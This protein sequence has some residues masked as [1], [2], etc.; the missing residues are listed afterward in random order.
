MDAGGWQILL[1]IIPAFFVGWFLLDWVRRPFNDNPR[2][3]KDVFDASPVTVIAA[4]TI[5]GS[6]IIWVVLAALG[7][8]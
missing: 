4:C 5:I 7:V 2:F 8:W 3:M 1:L 6:G